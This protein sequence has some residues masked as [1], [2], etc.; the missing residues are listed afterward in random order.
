MNGQQAV[1]ISLA[2][3][4]AIE[5]Q[6]LS[7]SETHDA[8]IRRAL[9]ERMPPRPR[10]P[11]RAHDRTPRAARRRGNCRVMI[12]GRMQP[13]MNLKEAY[14]VIL[15]ALVRHK[16]SLFQLLAVE[17]TT[18]RGWIAPSPEALF[19]TSPHLAARHAH[20]IAPNWFVDTNVSRGQIIARL[21][22]ACRIAGKRYG[23][24]VSIVES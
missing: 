22:V 13:V 24:D 6:R 5:A 2:T 18:R 14:L 15:T 8:I 19:G 3:Y 20:Q 12:D 21:T 16:A 7:F 23:N 17:G 1:A 11:D 4:K 10:V 9:A